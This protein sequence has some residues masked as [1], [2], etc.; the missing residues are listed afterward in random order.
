LPISEDIKKSLFWLYRNP[1]K[2]YR[3]KLLFVLQ[4]IQSG[5]GPDFEDKYLTNQT[6]FE[7][8]PEGPTE[9]DSINYHIRE[10]LWE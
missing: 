9:M 2:L 10:D 4:L 3:E 6:I 5:H 8:Y 1:L 7:P